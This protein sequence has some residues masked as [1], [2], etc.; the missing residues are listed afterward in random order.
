MSTFEYILT[1]YIAT[2]TI[3]SLVVVYDFRKRRKSWKDKQ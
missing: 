3:V 2:F 1:V